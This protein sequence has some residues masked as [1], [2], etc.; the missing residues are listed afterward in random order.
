MPV[1][2]C[3]NGINTDRAIELAAARAAKKGLT[4]EEELEETAKSIPMGRLARPE[5]QAAGSGLLS[6]GARC[7]HHR[8][9]PF[10]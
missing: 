5:E 2:E 9:L 10:G 1:F 8:N 4:A 6:L 3:S 7:L